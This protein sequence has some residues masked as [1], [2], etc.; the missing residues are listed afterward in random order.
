ME[1]EAVLNRLRPRC[2]EHV[3]KGRQL[4]ETVQRLR[5]ELQLCKA[6]RGVLAAGA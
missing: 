3:R 5:S 2:T 6:E 1:A 4:Y